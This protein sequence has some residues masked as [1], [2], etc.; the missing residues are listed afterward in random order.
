MC[1]GRGLGC[2]LVVFEL[3]T[4]VDHEFVAVVVVGVGAFLQDVASGVVG[5][6]NIVVFDKAT[7]FVVGVTCDQFA[8]CMDSGDVALVVV[9]VTATGGFVIGTTE[10]FHDRGRGSFGVFGVIRNFLCAEDA[11]DFSNPA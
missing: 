10:N 11:S 6:F 9:C 5:D 4:V 2:R 1:R 7:K 8:V 3:L